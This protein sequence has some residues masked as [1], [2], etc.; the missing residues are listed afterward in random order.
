MEGRI[1]ATEEER[2]GAALIEPI[3]IEVEPCISTKSQKKPSLLGMKP[4]N[5]KYRNM[6]KNRPEKLRYIYISLKKR[7]EATK[8]RLSLK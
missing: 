7:P 3:G 4:T 1:T 8:S 6:K 5:K 2:G